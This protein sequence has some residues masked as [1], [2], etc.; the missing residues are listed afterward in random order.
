[1]S[2][3][4]I[5]GVVLVIVAVGGFRLLA[6]RRVGA[7]DGRFAWIYFLPTL[8]IAGAWVVQGRGVVTRDPGLGLVV[9]VPSVL[10]AVFIARA[11]SRMARLTPT[12]RTDGSLDAIDAATTNDI[13]VV[14]GVV[15]IGGVLA[16]GALIVFGVLQLAS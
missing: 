6:A 8:V 16:A 7:G 12:A 10:F 1:M 11:A 13:V 14:L 5:A 4:Q 2:P 15:L 9:L 3:M